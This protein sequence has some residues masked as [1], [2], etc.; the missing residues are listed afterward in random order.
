VYIL[1]LISEILYFE[2]LINSIALFISSL[3]LNE[4]FSIFELSNNTIFESKISP[5]E[6]L[7]LT[8]KDQNS[9]GLNCSISCS[10]SVSNLNATD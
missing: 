1:E 5:F 6:V 2:F 8:F 10:L 4:N 3:F 7:K 9:S